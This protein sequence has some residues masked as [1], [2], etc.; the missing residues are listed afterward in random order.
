MMSSATSMVLANSS[1]YGVSCRPSG[2]SVTY[3]VSPLP[4]FSLP[5]SS[6]GRTMPVELP[7]VVTFTLYAMDVDYNGCYK[8]TMA[9]RLE[10]AGHWNQ[11]GCGLQIHGRVFDRQADVAAGFCQAA[12]RFR[13]VDSGFEHDEGHGNASAGRLD[14]LD[15]F[16]TGNAAG[17]NEN[18]DAALDQLGVLHVHV[19]HQVFVHVAQPG[20]GAGGDHV[21]DHLL[22]RRSLH[23]GGT[24]DD[25]GADLGDDGDVGG[26]SERGVRVAGDAGGLGSPGARVSDRGDDVGSASAGGQADDHV[27]P[28]GTTAS[29]IALTELLGI[30][31]N[32]DRGSE[33]FRASRHDVLNGLRSRGEV[34]RAFAG[35]ER[36]DASA[37]AGADVNQAASVA[38]A[39]GHRIDH[40]SDL[41]KRLL[42][43]RGHLGI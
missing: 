26:S 17:A 29:D 14:D 12:D 19:D 32:L 37:G 42:D 27:F 21:G 5:R 11:D 13:F 35:V 1:L 31:V 28:G 41:G 22:R 38:Q 36:S 16:F 30:L 4:I 6:L 34:R 8:T 7:T 9:S 20:H 15:C 39:A 43:R 2:V 18:P 25:L 40:Q 3:S 33:G 23:A 10:L 24:R